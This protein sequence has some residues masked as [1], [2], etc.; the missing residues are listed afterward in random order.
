MSSVVKND[1]VVINTEKK[2]LLSNPNYFNIGQETP[3]QIENQNNDAMEYNKLIKKAQQKAREIILDARERAKKTQDEAH[4]KAAKIQEMAEKEGYSKGHSQ[5]YEIGYKEGHKEGENKGQTQ[6]QGLIEEATQLKQQY[7]K[8]YEKLYTSSEGNMLELA[9]NIAKKIIG[10]AL[11]NDDNAYI[12]LAYRTLK[13]VQGQNRV[14]LK[15]SNQDFEKAV[16]NKELLISKLEGIDHIEIVE[17]AFLEKGS[18]VI[19]TGNGVIDGSANTQIETIESQ[20]ISLANNS[21]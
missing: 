9:I 6:Y 8:D 13:K 5:G 14:T 1:R 3:T 4:L 12:E 18:C 15:T 16:A 11:D 20:L 2:I 21:L 19:D 17:D 10:D 7:I